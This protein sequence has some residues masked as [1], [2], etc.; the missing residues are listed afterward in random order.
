MSG[1]PVEIA[2]FAGEWVLDLLLVTR[3]SVPILGEFV[4]RTRS[5]VAVELAVRDAGVWQTQR[6]CTTAVNDGRGLVRTRIPP[7]FVAALPVISFP[8]DLTPTPSGWDYAAD[9]GRQLIGWDGAG[10]LPAS[11]TTMATDTPASPSSWRRP[12]WAPARSTWCRPAAPACPAPGTARH[13][14]DRWPSPSFDR[15]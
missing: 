14:W 8:V 4:T 10:A 5:E 12:W 13:W 15:R 2:E 3:A 9:F 11:G 1:E 7:A 6:V